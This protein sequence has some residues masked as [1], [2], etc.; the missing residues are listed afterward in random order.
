MKYGCIP[1]IAINIFTVGIAKISRESTT[2][3]VGMIC[4]RAKTATKEV[5]VKSESTSDVKFED[6]D[7]DFA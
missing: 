7:P 3:C 6:M 2:M 4:Q 5:T 1:L